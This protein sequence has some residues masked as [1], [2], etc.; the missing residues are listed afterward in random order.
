MTE[1]ISQTLPKP[2]PQAH[3]RPGPGPDL[4][5]AP[6]EP[7]VFAPTPPPSSP[8]GTATAPAS[9][10]TTSIADSVV[11][12]I[13]GM[14]AREVRGIHAM[15]G[16]FTRGYGA[17]RDRVPGTGTDAS[18]GVKVEVGEKQTAVDLAVVVEYGVSIADVAAAVRAHVTDAVE[19]MTGLE[20]VAVDIAV[21]DVHLFDDAAQ[22]T[23]PRVE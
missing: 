17:V 7:R 3:I 12:K 2:Q 4:A 6:V 21:H 13:A 10:G 16:G 23:T 8:A 18:R 14:A 9:R 15:G 5:S 19:R 22:N 20:V 11:A 1:P